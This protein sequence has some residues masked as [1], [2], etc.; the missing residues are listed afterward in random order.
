[1][2]SNL[3]RK[4]HQIGGGVVYLE[5]EE[6]TQILEFY[7]SEANRF[8]IFGERYSEKDQTKYIQLLKIF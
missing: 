2:Q 7:Q 3:Q 5:C 4:K 1:M 8:R 6:K